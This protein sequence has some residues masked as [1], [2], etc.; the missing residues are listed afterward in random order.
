MLNSTIIQ[1][2]EGSKKGFKVHKPAWRLMGNSL[3]KDINSTKYKA[4]L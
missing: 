2:K 3:K 4:L 1:P